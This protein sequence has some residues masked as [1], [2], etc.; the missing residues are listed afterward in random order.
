[1]NQSPKDHLSNGPHEQG[2]F[3]RNVFYNSAGSDQDRV[4]VGPNP[5]KDGDQ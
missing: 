5:L 1:M 2:V 3:Q 4:G